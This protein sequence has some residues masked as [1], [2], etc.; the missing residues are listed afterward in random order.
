MLPANPTTSVDAYFAASE[1]PT[2]VFPQTKKE[3]RKPE[4]CVSNQKKGLQKRRLFHVC[5]QAHKSCIYD[6]QPAF[7][8]HVSRL[9]M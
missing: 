3:L 5:K 6:V 1:T 9:H 2:I 7:R 8:A 4:F